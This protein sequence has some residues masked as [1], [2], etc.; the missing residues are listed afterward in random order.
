MPKH[1]VTLDDKYALEETQQ[2]LTRLDIDYLQGFHLG[3]PAPTAALEGV[4]EPALQR[5]PPL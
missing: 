4:K 2:L 3:R 5:H 1:T